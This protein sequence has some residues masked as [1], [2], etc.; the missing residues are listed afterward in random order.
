VIRGVRVLPFTERLS[1]HRFVARCARV[2][3]NG[4]TYKLIGA[5]TW[6]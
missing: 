1:D 6:R 5:Q 3:P 4:G 2:T